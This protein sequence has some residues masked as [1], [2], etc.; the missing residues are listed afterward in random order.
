MTLRV[1]GIPTEIVERLRGGGMDANGQPAL[2]RIAEGQANP[3]RHCIDLIADGDEKLVLAYRPF[4]DLQPYA[5]V[6][7]I[8]LHRTPCTRYD[9][10]AMP[11]WFEFLEPAIVRGYGADDWIRYDTGQVVAGRELG[12]TCERILGDPSIAYVHVRSK[13]NCFQCRVDRG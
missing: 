2:V 1:R 11:W 5:E 3:C 8:F 10:A 4:G 7:P 6:G 12:A 9:Q 13:F